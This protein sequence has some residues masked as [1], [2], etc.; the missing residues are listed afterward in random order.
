VSLRAGHPL[1]PHWDEIGGNWRYDISYENA[2]IHVLG[3]DPGEPVSTEDLGV[4]FVLGDATAHAGEVVEIPVFA[5]TEEN[6]GVLRLALESDPDLHVESMEVDFI[7]HR[8][9]NHFWRVI[10]RGEFWYH[11]RCEGE[12]CTS[13]TPGL[14]LLYDDVEPEQVLIDYILGAFDGIAVEGWVTSELREVARLRVRVAEDAQPRTA[15]LRPSCFVWER[16]ESEVCSGGF[17][18]LGDHRFGPAV[19]VEGG[20]ITITGAP[21]FLRGDCNDDG[22]V[23]ISDAVCILNWLFSGGATP[24]CVAVTNTN[25]DPNTDLSDAVYVLAHLFLGGPP[26]VPPFPECGPRPV[27]ETLGCETPPAHCN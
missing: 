19:A 11:E 24:G 13:S 27:G 10:R 8:D 2:F 6:F 12:R 15:R 14:A 9:L 22:H 17:V 21:W 3:E 18:S 4:A 7:D 25:G 20:H 5:S 16:D 26:P 1:P 23:D